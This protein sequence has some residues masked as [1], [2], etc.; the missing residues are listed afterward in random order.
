MDCKNAPISRHV[1]VWKP[2]RIQVMAID[3]S[4]A[5]PFNFSDYRITGQLN[6]KK[7]W[8]KVSEIA[9]R[10]IIVFHL[11]FTMETMDGDCIVEEWWGRLIICTVLCPWRP[12]EANAGEKKGCLYMLILQCHESVGMVKVRRALCSQSYRLCPWE[13]SSSQWQRR[14]REPHASCS[15]GGTGMSHITW[16]TAWQLGERIPNEKMRRCIDPTCIARAT[17]LIMCQVSKCQGSSARAT[18]YLRY[19][20]RTVQYR[21]FTVTNVPASGY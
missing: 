13:K 18:R 6:T 16:W 20:T 19:S 1:V 15:H 14:E 11:L 5:L 10:R 12:D 21:T 9:N 7:M 17:G 4:A 2:S 3:S 8:G